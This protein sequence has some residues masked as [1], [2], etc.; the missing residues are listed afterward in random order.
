VEF[1]GPVVEYAGLAG[2]QKAKLGKISWPKMQGFQTRFAEVVKQAGY[3]WLYP[4]IF[5]RLRAG[6]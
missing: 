2:G 3:V 1:A 4:R 6:F 5:P